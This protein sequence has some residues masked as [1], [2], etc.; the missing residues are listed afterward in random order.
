VGHGL[1]P[2]ALRDL[3][4]DDVGSAYL[5]WM[6][7]PAVVRYLESRFAVHTEA[8]LRA[9][10]VE[11]AARDDTLLLAIVERDGGRHVGNIKV[12]PLA[13]HHGTADVGLLIGERDVWGR[14]YA[15][16]AIRQAT[17]LAWDRLGARKLTASCYSGNAASARA[18]LRA[19]WVDEGRR[20][21]QFLDDDGDAHDQLLLGI[22]R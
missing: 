13:A 6:T 22:V 21:A 20:P 8:S 14:G 15:T 3:R 2:V 17:D 11:Q 12:G 7:D 18:F 4:P 16:A 5:R 9:W 19:G 10:V 1:S